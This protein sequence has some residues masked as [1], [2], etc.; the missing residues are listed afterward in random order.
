MKYTEHSRI[1]F[2]VQRE[3]KRQLK[4]ELKQLQNVKKNNQSL[5]KT[6]LEKLLK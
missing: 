2:L 6:I 3:V 4:K 5:L 1:K